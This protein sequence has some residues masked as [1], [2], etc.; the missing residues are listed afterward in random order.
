MKTESKITNDPPIPS[1]KKKSSSISITPEDFS[2]KYRLGKG[3]YGDVFLV[4]KN[5]D[6]I[7]Y[8]MKQIQKKKLEK[9]K[10]EYQA[11]I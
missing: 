11:L 7:L 5:S 3:A 6:Q 2:V 4:L 9:E 1:P 10:K 8:A